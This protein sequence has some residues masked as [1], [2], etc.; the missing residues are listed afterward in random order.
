MYICVCNAITEDDI[1]QA[2]DDGAS[3]FGCLQQSLGVST[4]CGQCKDKA[5]EVAA[6]HLDSGRP[7]SGLPIVGQPTLH[8]LTT[9]SRLN[10]AG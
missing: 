10:L 3:S 2:V 6:A 9:D 5:L 8:A 7:Y 4:C 1:K